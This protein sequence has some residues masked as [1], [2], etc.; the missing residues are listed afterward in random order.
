MLTLARNIAERFG[1][2]FYRPN[3]FHIV[4]D[5]PVS[6]QPRYGTKAPPPAA[7]ATMI[8]ESR[9]RYRDFLAA[10]AAMKP[11]TDT[12]AIEPDAD[13]ERP[14]WNSGWL[15]PRDGVAMMHF[16]MKHKP[17]R[18][19]EIGS[20]NSTKFARLAIRHAGLATTITSIDPEPRAEIDRIC[21][22][23]IRSGLQDVDLAIFDALEAGDILSFDGSHR[24]FS[25]SDVT[26]F[27]LE[28]IP[29]LAAGVIV[30][31]HDIF[32]PLDYPAEW[33]ARFYSEQYLL[34]ML[35]IAARS[36]IEVL[37]ANAF[38]D[39]DEE[40]RAL[41]RDLLPSD[42]A[43]LGRFGEGVWANAFWFRL[44]EKIT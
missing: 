25:D 22:E 34:G 28:V 31:V 41:A 38:V 7:I 19:L 10:V 33:G 42:P 36:K 39:Q 9:P 26:V 1:I 17:K 18:F 44:N 3:P 11:L 13:P 32:W 2:R 35:L 40:L 43:L 30:Q 29:R 15:P 21:D 6:D 4:T 8:E 20:G 37:L 5:Y 14:Y 23:V 16:L 27:F 24:V 12:I